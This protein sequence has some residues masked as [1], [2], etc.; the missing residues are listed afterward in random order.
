MASP[1]ESI[2]DEFGVLRPHYQYLRKASSKRE[3]PPQ[4]T[5]MHKSA[6]RIKTLWDPEDINANI[7]NIMKQRPASPPTADFCTLLISQYWSLGP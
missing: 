1:F 3:K 7:S 4:N 5:S 6:R 2:H